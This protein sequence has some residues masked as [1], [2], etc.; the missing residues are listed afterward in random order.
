MTNSEKL[1]SSIVAGPLKGV[2]KIAIAGSELENLVGR[3]TCSFGVEP[4]GLLKDFQS[5]IS[6]HCEIIS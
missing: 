1:L 4:L 5:A 6:F 2:R 3:E